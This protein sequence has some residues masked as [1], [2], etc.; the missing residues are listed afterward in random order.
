MQTAGQ[1]LESHL[2]TI[3][4]RSLHGQDLA[5]KLFAASGE[6]GRDF[7][8]LVWILMGRLPALGRRLNSSEER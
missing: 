5:L 6:R 3:A 1:A 4:G 2:Q 8:S 7:I